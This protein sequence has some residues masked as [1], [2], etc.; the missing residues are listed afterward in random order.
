MITKL[1]LRNFKSIKEETY[2]F[3]SLDLFVGWNNSGKSTV[4]QSLAIWQF[5]VDEFRRS[6]R[7]GKK[8]IQ[9]ILPNFTALPVPVFNLL[10][11]NKTDRKYPENPENPDKKLQQ[12]ITIDI[13]VTWRVRDNTEHTFGVALR[14]HS[15]QTVYAIPKTDWDTFRKHDQESELPIVAYVPPFS[16]LEPQE[17]RRDDAP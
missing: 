12:F 3:T 8:G 11:H 14:Y 17:E 7:A 10:W 6:R 16:G 4:L 1:T 5:C 9:V 15:A 13:E 2:D